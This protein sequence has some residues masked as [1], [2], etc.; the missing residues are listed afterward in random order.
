MCS[1][2]PGE[3]PVWNL[4]KFRTTYYKVKITKITRGEGPCTQIVAKI[5]FLSCQWLEVNMGQN[6]NCARATELYL[7]CRRFKRLKRRVLLHNRCS[8]PKVIA[9]AH[10]F[11]INC[12]K[13]LYTDWPLLWEMSGKSSFLKDIFQ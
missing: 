11:S 7:Q 10:L 13:G 12:M 3:S 8:D 9:H 6:I 5:I 2:G 1:T 4:S